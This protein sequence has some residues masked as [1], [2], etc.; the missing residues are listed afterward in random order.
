MTMIGYPAHRR[1]AASVI[2]LSHMST[3]DVM[4]FAE[5]MQFKTGWLLAEG[6]QPQLERVKVGTP[7]F[8]TLGQLFAEQRIVKTEGIA[9]GSLVFVAASADAPKPPTD[10]TLL[11]WADAQ[12]LPWVEIIDNEIAYWGGLTEAQIDRLLAWFCC[13]RPMECDWLKARLDQ[14]TAARLRR[15]LF[16]HGWTRNLEL[17]KPR[18]PMLDLWGGAHRSCILDHTSVPVLSQVNAG[19]RLTLSGDTWIGADLGDRCIL[20]DDNGKLPLGR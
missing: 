3:H 1:S 15:G 11:A 16:D 19:V 18:K 13:Q 10:R 12:T 6:A 5:Q 14:K 9:S 2:G 4:R 7:I 20:S 8:V 17:A